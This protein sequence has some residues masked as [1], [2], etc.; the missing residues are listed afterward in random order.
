M[1]ELAVKMHNHEGVMQKSQE[2][3]ETNLHASL[4]ANSNY[5]HYNGHNG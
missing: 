3:H 4:K 2:L 1:K 5:R